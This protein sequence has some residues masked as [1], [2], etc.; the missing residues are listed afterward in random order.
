MGD[1]LSRC[2]EFGLYSDSVGL[3]LLGILRMIDFYNVDVGPVLFL[4]RYCGIF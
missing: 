3:Y 4:R 2:Y 1:L